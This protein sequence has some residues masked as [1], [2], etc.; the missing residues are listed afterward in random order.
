MRKKNT[1]PSVFDKA[2]EHIGLNQTEELNDVDNLDNELLFSNTDDVDPDKKD[3]SEGNNE[4]GLN[5][6]EDDSDIPDNVF[7]NNNSSENKD[8]NDSQDKDNVDNNDNIDNEDVD[9][10]DENE[11]NQVSAFFDAF[12][13]ANGWAVDEDEKPT[14]IEDLIS[15]ISN[16][17]EENSVPEY[18]DPRIK[19]LD[20]YVKNGGSFDDFYNGMSEELKYDSLDMEDESN[21]KAVIKEYLKLQGY[22]DDQVSSKLERYEDADMLEDEAN[23]AVE[24]LKNIKQQQLEEQ[25][26]AQ[27]LEYEER[28][29]QIVEF[30]ENLNKEIFNL[31]NIRGL[32]IPKE[33]RKQLFDYITKVDKDGYTQ[34]QKDFGKNQIKNIIESAYFTMKG[35]A[36]LT[37]AA[38]GGQTSAVKKLRQIMKSSS[39]NHSSKS[40]GDE[41]KISAVDIAS[42]YFS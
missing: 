22:S 13:E 42:K 10:I 16:I 4:D 5:I 38:K 35:D 23:D 21:Q 6:R 41:N 34:Y 33:D 37:E 27:Q 17:V 15:Y 7:N 19:Q 26:R 18:S 20:E 40:L 30:S 25:Q 14:T 8:N 39:K 12:A 1:E 3:E 28:Q 24:I 2:F 32:N 11:T 29:R 9:E 31:T 36:L